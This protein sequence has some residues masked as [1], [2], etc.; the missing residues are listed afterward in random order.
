MN[1]KVSA[2]YD[3]GENMLAGPNRRK[4]ETDGTA[5][6]TK[7]SKTGN[8]TMTRLS[9]W[10]TTP[11]IKSKLG[12]ATSPPANAFESIRPLIA[13]CNLSPYN[14]YLITDSLNFGPPPAPEHKQPTSPPTRGWCNFTPFNP[15]AQPAMV[16]LS[17]RQRKRWII[18]R[19]IVDVFPC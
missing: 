4:Q 6:D 19:Q 10:P 13:L 15:S 16:R 8:V 11:R 9:D 1:R 5:E 18:H 7:M 14:P 3:S 2:N 12:H 17:L